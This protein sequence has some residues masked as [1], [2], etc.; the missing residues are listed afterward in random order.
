MTR[1]DRHLWAR[2]LGSFAVV[3]GASC[4]LYGVIDFA[5]RSS[6][7]GG[8]AWMIWVG[9]LYGYRLLKVAALLAPV[10][11]LMGAGLV[12]SS[13]RRRSEWIA[14]LAAGLSPFRLIAPLVASA[15]ALG[16]LTTVFDDRIAGAA[17]LRA[18]QISAEHFHL[19]GSYAAYFEPKRWVRVGDSILHVGRPLPGGGS[20]DVSIFRLSPEFALVERIDAARLI[21]E[22]SGHFRLEQAQ[23]RRFDDLRQQLSQVPSMELQLPAADAL[24]ALAPGRPEMLSRAELEKQVQVRELLGL[25]SGEQRYEAWARLANG[26]AGAAGALVAMALALRPR[27]RGHINATLVEG[28]AIAGALW[29]TMAVFKSLSLAG[30]LPTPMSAVAPIALAGALG[31]WGL[32]RLSH[33]PNA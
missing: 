21:P 18:E 22:G 25:P 31:L 5:D 1:I 12:V 7:Y 17:A 4:L 13:L 14:L 33:E 10:A 3:L 32:W 16:L 9:K 15:L 20:R 23:V 27:R 29:A 28:I 24:F 26:F 19:W 8:R 2:H 6:A 30:R 11:S